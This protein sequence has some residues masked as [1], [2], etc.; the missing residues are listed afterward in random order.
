MQA[1]MNTVAETS[2]VSGGLGA[3]TV[4]ADLAVKASLT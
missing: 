4:A 3:A 1:I 2:F